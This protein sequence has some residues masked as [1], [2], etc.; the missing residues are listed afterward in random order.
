MARK[1]IVCLDGTGNEIGPDISNV[2]KLC[3]MIEREPGQLVYYDP[4]VD[5]RCVE[6]PVRGAASIAEEAESVTAVT[7]KV[8][9]TGYELIAGMAGRRAGGSDGA[10]RRASQRARDGG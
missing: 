7:G 3:R 4:G 1:L 6:I 10:K 8:S 2:L 9:R 5:R